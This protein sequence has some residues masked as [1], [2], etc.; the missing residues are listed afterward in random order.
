MDSRY[1]TAKILNTSRHSGS[2]LVLHLL[3]P[4]CIRLMVDFTMYEH[5]P[6]TWG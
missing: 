3:K 5:T 1:G 4:Q 6:G 2:E